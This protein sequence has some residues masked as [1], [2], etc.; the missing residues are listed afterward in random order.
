MTEQLALTGARIVDP[1]QGLDEVGWLLIRD[2]RIVAHGTD[3]DAL[4]ARVAE[5]DAPL[6]TVK[7]PTRWVVAPGFVDLHAHLREPGFEGKETIQRLLDLVLEPYVIG[8]AEHHIRR[9]SAV[10]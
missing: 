4:A 3:A 10:Q 2:G 6:R 7:L 9:I 8:I 1:G 5:S